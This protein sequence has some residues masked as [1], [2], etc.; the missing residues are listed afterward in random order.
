MEQTSGTWK[1]SKH[2]W[3]RA[4]RH[5]TLIVFGSGATEACRSR[6]ISSLHAR[7][8]KLSN[9]GVMKVRLTN[10]REKLAGACDSLAMPN[11]EAT[12]QTTVD[13]LGPGRGAIGLGIPQFG[14][15]D[16]RQVQTQTVNS[17]ASQCPLAI[18]SCSGAS[19]DLVGE[20]STSRGRTLLTFGCDGPYGLHINVN[21]SSA[22]RPQPLGDRS[23]EPLHQLKGMCL[24]CS[25]MQQIE[26]GGSMLKECTGLR[27]FEVVRFLC[28]RVHGSIR[29]HRQPAVERELLAATLVGRG[30][31]DCS[32]KLWHEHWQKALGARKAQRSALFSSRRGFSGSKSNPQIPLTETKSYNLA[33]LQAYIIQLHALRPEFPIVEPLG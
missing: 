7:C 15:P 1:P 16:A 26:V 2:C 29:S 28:D 33:P 23:P 5:V 30:A 32:G 18:L 4:A 6:R 3:Q 22:L 20:A 31:L 17:S 13:T 19:C 8:R 24:C 10:S 27:D 21:T 12:L 14:P 11:F 25:Y 9:F